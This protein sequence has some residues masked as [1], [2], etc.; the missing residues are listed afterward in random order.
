[1]SINVHFL[2]VGQGNMVVAIF[3]D[4]KVMVYDCN[5]T[6]ENEDKIFAYLEKIMPKNEIDVFVN[7]HRDADHMRGI[8]KLHEKYKINTLWDSGVSG[9]TEAPEYQE[10]MDFRRNMV[11][12]VCEVHSNEYWTGKPFVRILN[13]K[14]E[15]LTDVNAQS[16][17]I[18]I[19]N[20]GCSILLAGD[21]DAKVWKDYIT[22]ESTSILKSSILLASHHGALSFF[23]D[24]TY[25]NY[26]TKHLSEI[27]PDMTIISVGENPHG[28]PDKEAIKL[29]EKYSNGSDK[30]NKVFRTDIRGNIKLE[31]KDDGKWILTSDK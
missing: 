19:D 5:I 2:D 4:C 16:I 23:Y 26:Y 13:G 27:N 21:T 10:Y 18:H 28:H 31:L 7:S 22:S 6:D 30:G 25:T 11:N 12:R 15:D 3:P 1:M 8:K 29:Y 9:N 24:P 20:N 14:R 17:V